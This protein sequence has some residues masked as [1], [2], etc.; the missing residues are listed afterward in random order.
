MSRKDTWDAWDDAT[1]ET[2][3]AYIY[4]MATKQVLENIIE[5]IKEAGY[6]GEEVDRIL[7]VTGELESIEMQV[8]EAETELHFLKSM[9][10]D[11]VLEMFG[12]RT[13]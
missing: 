9:T 6:Y 7:G 1:S 4:F 8:A 12:G 2:E 5:A 11:E 13:Q 3:G 10:E